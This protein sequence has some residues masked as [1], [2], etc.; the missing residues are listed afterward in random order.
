MTRGA[1][2]L[3]AFHGA[4]LGSRVCELRSVLRM[5]RVA[6]SAVLGLAVATAACAFP[7]ALDE[8]RAVATL[9]G[10]KFDPVA[11]APGAVRVFVFVSTECPIANSYAPRLCE[12]AQGWNG[13]DV[14]FVLVHVDPEVTEQSLRSHARDYA[15]PFAIV[16]DRTHSLARALGITTTPEVAVV[17]RSG[18]VYRGRLDDRW[19]GRGQ[20]G[21][22][23]NV[24]DLR[25][26]VDGVLR[27]ESQPFR[28]TEPVGCRLP[29]QP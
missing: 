2:V 4:R 12:L 15:L 22:Q 19:G 23:A 3:C 21:Q 1:E 29:A 8:S 13:R 28:A 7:P 20:D 27:G 9:D 25:D 10:A 17:A 26:V 11:V 14:E 16:H 5:R 18:L 6:R 24:H